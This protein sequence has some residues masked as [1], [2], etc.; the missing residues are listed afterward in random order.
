ML[1]LLL[2]SA[3]VMISTVAMGGPR[4]SVCDQRTVNAIAESFN[5]GNNF[6]S[7]GIS[8]IDVVVESTKSDTPT[9]LAC[10]VTVEDNKGNRDKMIMLLQL[11]DSGSLTVGLKAQD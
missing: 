9:E 5:E 8:I 2:A 10:N 4:G 3:M 7:K 1:K 6:K 11:R